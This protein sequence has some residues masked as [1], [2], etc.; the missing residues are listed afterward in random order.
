[1]ASVLLLTS[2]QSPTPPPPLP[3]L[4]RT[5]P[6]S[7]TPETTESFKPETS[8]WSDANMQPKLWPIRHVWDEAHMPVEEVRKAVRRAFRGYFRFLEEQITQPEVSY[9]LVGDFNGDGTRDLAVSVVFPAIDLTQNGQKIPCVQFSHG[10]NRPVPFTA[11]NLGGHGIEEPMN[12]FRGYYLTSPNQNAP[13]LAIIHGR[14]DGNWEKVSP[15]NKFIFLTFATDLEFQL[16]LHHG[17]LQSKESRKI[18]YPK[19]DA[20]AIYDQHYDDSVELGYDWDGLYW[21]GR[22]YHWVQYLKGNFPK[23]PNL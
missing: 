20:I 22:T 18:A 19:G 4:I 5:L 23:N 21:D 9:Y 6:V 11:L 7:T 2:C 14:P 1:M 13:F 10:D 16:R 3:P 12:D 15:K 8:E 17:P